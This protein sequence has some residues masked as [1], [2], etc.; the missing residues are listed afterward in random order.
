MSQ[1]PRR[2][3]A[4]GRSENRAYNTPEQSKSPYPEQGLAPE[5]HWRSTSEVNALAENSQRP[6]IPT[7][8]DLRFNGKKACKKSE[9]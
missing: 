9:N 1:N 4:G 3:P 8:E 6:R 5:H 7:S 2:P